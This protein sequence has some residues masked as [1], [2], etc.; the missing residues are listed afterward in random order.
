MTRNAS[1]AL[2]LAC[3]PATGLAQ[4]FE[5]PLPLPSAVI[6]R[7][8]EEIPGIPAVPNS[9]S[10]GEQTRPRCG[11]TCD[12]VRVYGTGSPSKSSHTID[13]A[14]LDLRGG[15]VVRAV[16]T[17]A[18][19]T[20]KPGSYPPF[21]KTF[22]RDHV[23]D[24]IRQTA[25]AAS[26][27]RH[28]VRDFYTRD[29][30]WEQDG[31]LW[32][33]MVLCPPVRSGFRKWRRATL[34][35]YRVVTVT[36]GGRLPRPAAPALPIP[37]STRESVIESLGEPDRVLTGDDARARC[38]D[39]CD[40]ILAYDPVPVVSAALSPTHSEI[41]LRNGSVVQSTWRSQGS[42]VRPENHPDAGELLGPS[43]IPRR[44]TM[45]PARGDG[46]MRTFR[47]RTDTAYWTARAIPIRRQ[48]YDIETDRIV[49]SSD[50]KALDH[51][52]AEVVATLAADPL[53]PDGKAAGAA[54]EIDPWAPSGP[55]GV[56]VDS[57]YQDVTALAITPKPVYKPSPP[58]PARARNANI[59]GQVVMMIRVSRDGTVEKVDLLESHPLFDL[60][61]ARTVA[62]W[63]FEPV[64]V[65]GKAIPWKMR[66]TLKFRLR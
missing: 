37:G 38:G 25:Q 3:F 46:P 19:R 42:P 32:T 9:V 6:G 61:A 44:A 65:K 23:P 11:N 62:Q 21:R 56:D 8:P 20:G 4:G 26:R 39:L 53:E 31:V 43:G 7:A 57:Q 15:K 48:I 58:Y 5:T 2:F 27:V 54:E 1:V 52:V 49:P 41:A 66:V 40:E 36:L 28:G 29:L 18:G 34:E 64:I 16:W 33:A 47:W 13:K 22:P 59:T 60:P 17:Y 55:A 63:R 10:T 35:E 50:E 51:R 14:I 45:D 24:G 30:A 12:E